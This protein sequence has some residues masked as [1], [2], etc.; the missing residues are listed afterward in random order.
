M[1]GR[2]IP[3]LNWLRVFEAAAQAES[4]ARAAERLGMS[5]AAV[6]QQ[7]RAL[8]GRLG[9]ALFDRGAQRVRLTP[10]GRA[11]LPAVAQALGAIELTATTL[12]GAAGERAAGGEIVA[13]RAVSLLAMGWLPAELAAFEAAHPGT[14]VDVFTGNQIGNFSEPTPGRRADLQILFGDRSDV[15]ADAT[16]LFGETLAPAARPAVAAEIAA[17]ADPAAALIAHRLFDVSGHRS[18]WPEALAALR[19]EID[20]RALRLSA[21]DSTP[22]ALVRAAAGDGVALARPPASDALVAA[23]GLTTPAGWPAVPGAQR[24]FILETPT[25]RPNPAARRLRDW[26]MQAAA[27]ST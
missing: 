13:L 25:R 26:L 9:A 8:E 6:S 7:I 15:D 21:T 12:F 11:F 18:G 27:R 20:L 22:I 19:P 1:S 16:P 24:Y 5:A 4:F 23:L 3:S 14:R 2:N 17:A 10:A